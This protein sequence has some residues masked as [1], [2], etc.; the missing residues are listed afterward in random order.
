MTPVQMEVCHG[1]QSQGG[2]VPVL[3]AA[4]THLWFTGFYSPVFR[5]SLTVYCSTANKYLVINDK[6][7]SSRGTWEPCLK[8][9]LLQNNQPCLWIRWPQIYFL[10]SVC[11]Y[12]LCDWT[13]REAKCLA[14]WKI[15]KNGRHGGRE[16]SMVLDVAARACSDAVGLPSRVLGKLCSGGNGTPPGGQISLSSRRVKYHIPQC[17]AAWLQFESRQLATVWPS[18]CSNRCF[19]L[20][21]R[22]LHN[23][24]F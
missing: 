23:L 21:Q 8:R 15:S 5:C 6:W 19:R 3:L 16:L 17:S 1:F 24:C 18:W 20:W 7:G 13:P 12:C 14:L 4:C 9:L 11:L 2:I 22:N 10:M